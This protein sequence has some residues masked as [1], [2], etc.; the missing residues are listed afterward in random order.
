MDVVKDNNFSK[1]TF[2]VRIERLIA[3]EGNIASIQDELQAPA[4]IINWSS[5]CC[6]IFTNILATSDIDRNEI[7][8]AYSIADLKEKQMRKEY[9]NCRMLAKSIF[10]EKPVYYND[11][12]FN[13]PFPLNAN[14]KLS[15]VNLVLSVN[16]RHIAE[17]VTPLLPVLLTQRLEN[18]KNE[19]DAALQN[20][21]L[22]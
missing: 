8:G 1:D 16:Q 9:Q 18:A 3:I 14:D 20:I 5:N 21:N 7:S 4:H 22:E 2:G 13:E 12:G 10:R 15:R 11:Y 6:S 17:A 19:Y